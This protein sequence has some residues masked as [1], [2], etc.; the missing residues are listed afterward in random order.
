[1]RVLVKADYSQLQ[2][3][4][5]AKIADDRAM[6]DAYG[7]GE[8]LHTLTAQR[9]TGKADG[10]KAD[11]QLAKAVN[12]GLLFGMG[13]KA[14]R[15]YAKSN[16]GLDLTE[17]EAEAYRKAFFVA[18]PG[19]KQWHNGAGSRCKRAKGDTLEVRTLAGR[20]RVLFRSKTT[21]SL[22]YTEQLNAPV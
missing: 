6:L 15:A 3:R 17:Q 18:Y 19:L 9:L 22:P 14:L 2:L 4:I 13:A 5:A 16:Y 10:T 1:G 20:R 7:R 11:R 21:G 8:D 12:F